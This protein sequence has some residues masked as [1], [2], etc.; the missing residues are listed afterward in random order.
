ME[1]WGQSGS[2]GDWLGGGVVEWIQ[3]AKDSD[4]WR[5]VVNAVMNLL[6]LAPRSCLVRWLHLKHNPTYELL[7]AQNEEDI[8]ST[9]CLQ[10]YH[11]V[12]TGTLLGY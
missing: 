1:G 4:R 10:P 5:A 8:G 6:V 2:R 9:E 7:R 11:V 12:A 3:L